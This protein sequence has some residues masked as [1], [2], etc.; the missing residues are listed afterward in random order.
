MVVFV[1]TEVVGEE[2]YLKKFNNFLLGLIHPVEPWVQNL[3]RKKSEHLSS[4]NQKK[5]VETGNPAR[6]C[7][8]TFF[9]ECKILSLKSKNY[10]VSCVKQDFRS[11]WGAIPADREEVVPI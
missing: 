11:V 9:I 1:N 3:P 6:R 2:N 7:Q 10:G 4:I 8:F 5:F